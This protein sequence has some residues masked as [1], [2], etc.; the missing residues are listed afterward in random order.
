MRHSKMY[1]YIISDGRAVKIGK[2]KNVAGRL[3]SLQTA[4]PTTL[5]L[6]AS[7]EGDRE[8]E[9]H[10]L[11]A[12][13]RLRGEWFSLSGGFFFW[14]MCQTEREDRVGTLARDARDDEHFPK[15]ENE[16]REIRNTL[17]RHHTVCRGARLALACAYREWLAVRRSAGVCTRVVGRYRYA[18]DCQAVTFD[19]R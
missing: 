13:H 3:K 4:S 2:T 9:L 7:F 18:L 5:Y 6:L 15:N 17:T 10:T 12:Q 11:Y 8:K 16:Y 19:S 14:L 1:T